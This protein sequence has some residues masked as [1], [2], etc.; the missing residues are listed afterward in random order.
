MYTRDRTPTISAEKW[1]KGE[2]TYLLTGHVASYSCARHAR[3]MATPAS[4][5]ASEKFMGSARDAAAGMERAVRA[6][7]RAAGG[8][9]DNKAGSA[10]FVS[11]PEGGKCCSRPARDVARADT[12][13]QGREPMLVRLFEAV[14]EQAAPVFM[15]VAEL[16]QKSD[17]ALAGVLYY[18]GR[19][20]AVV[21]SL[22]VGKDAATLSPCDGIPL[23]AA[24]ELAYGGD[25]PQEV[26]LQVA[27]KAQKLKWQPTAQARQSAA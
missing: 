24:V 12:E 10:K 6:T 8:A 21:P 9:T 14:R 19:R 17:A 27:L 4:E 26:S 3:T 15:A 13:P 11:H 22:R 23:V 2:L 18:D 16:L 5:R 20:G 1:P 7:K 25:D